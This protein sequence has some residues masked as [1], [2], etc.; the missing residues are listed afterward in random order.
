MS[1][2]EH[3]KQIRKISKLLSLA[4]RHQ[5]ERLS[6]ELD[7]HGWTDTS[8]LIN[9]LNQQGV[10]MDMN[11]LI[12]VVQEN[13][14]QRFAFNEDQSRIRANQGHSVTIDLQL[15]PATP[16]E[17]LYHGTVPRFMD[18]I[19]VDGLMKM[20]RQHVH[21]SPDIETARKVG[22]RRGQPII[23]TIATG[24]MHRAGHAFFISENKVWL[25]DHVPPK[26]IQFR[27]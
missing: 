10:A 27:Q 5:P 1:T 3:Q 15:A 11:L 16:P 12:T 6:I 2:H 25:T 8:R 17:Y 18:A 14:K 21:L 24:Q 20:S 13:D 26:Y 23:L 19:R 4:L 9:A 22:S 7:K